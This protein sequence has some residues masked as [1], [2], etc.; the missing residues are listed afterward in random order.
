MRARALAATRRILAGFDISL[1][2]LSRTM[3]AR[4]ARFVADAGVTVLVDVGAHIGEYASEARRA[5][6]TGRIESFEPLRGSY[7]ALAARAEGDP[8]WH[9]HRLALGDASGTLTMHVAGNDVSSSALAMLPSHVAGDPRSAY[10]GTQ[11]AEATR[12]DDLD[13]AGPSDVLYVKVDVQGY[14][15]RVLAGGTRTLERAALVELELSL[16]RLYE[17][18]PLCAEMIQYLAELGFEPIWLDRAFLD[19]RTGR[20]LQVDAIF[21]RAP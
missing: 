12:L 14:E 5:G 21:A 10:V 7:E 16:V 17:G 3:P 18:G 1:G 11:E 19:E 8:L 4:R 20:M 15:R 2:R 13:I 9:C 6:F